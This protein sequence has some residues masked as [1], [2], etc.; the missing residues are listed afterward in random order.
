MNTTVTGANIKQQYEP[1]WR[2]TGTTSRIQN[3]SRRYLK[4]PGL[5]AQVDL[6][7]LCP[8]VAADG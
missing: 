1:L 8:P 7:H 6:A 3:T 2:C 5:A 4:G